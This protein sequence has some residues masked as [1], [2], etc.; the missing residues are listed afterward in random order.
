MSNTQSAKISD[1]AAG[2]SG[3]AENA[4]AA[5]F[6]AAETGS[7]SPA[8]AFRLAARPFGSTAR[9][10]RAAASKSGRGRGWGAG[11]AP[12]RQSD[13]RFAAGP[14]GS[15][16]AKRRSRSAAAS[17]LTRRILARPR[18]SAARGGRARRRRR[19][20]RRAE[21]RREERARRRRQTGG[22]PSPAL[23]LARAQAGIGAGG[24]KACRSG[25]FVER[26]LGSRAPAETAPKRRSC[27]CRRRVGEQV[28]IGANHWGMMSL[29]RRFVTLCGDELRPTCREVAMSDKIALSDMIRRPARNPCQTPQNQALSPSW[30]D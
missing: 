18:R 23:P 21:L 5:A 7:P 19:A 4:R 9:S 11:S 20:D 26:C 3:R 10:S 8:Q 13:R 30:P 17:A 1:G 22:S 12:S 14:S 16:T 2:A 15:P 28:E 24:G 27:T 25:V 29:A 6:A